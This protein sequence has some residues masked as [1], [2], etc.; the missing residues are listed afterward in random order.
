MDELIQVKL[1]EQI[2]SFVATTTGVN[3]S[4]TK[5]TREVTTTVGLHDGEVVVLG[6]LVQDNELQ[7][8]THE[9]WLPHFLDGRSGGKGRTEV[10]LVLQV[11]KVSDL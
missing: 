10:L 1:D 2:S 3:N 7:A 4:P 9:G 8:V 5:N 6:G 11:S